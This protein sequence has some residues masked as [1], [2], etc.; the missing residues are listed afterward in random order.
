MH[1]VVLLTTGL[2]A[3]AVAM[4]ESRKRVG[5]T[6]VELLVVIA[7][8]GVL[9]ALLLPA[10]QAAREAARRSQCINNLKQIGLAVQMYHDVHQSVVPSRVPCHHAT[11]AALLWPYLEQNSASQRWLP[12][13]TFYNQPEENLQ[14][15]IST[16]LCPSRRSAPQLS[17]DGD[18]RAYISH[19]PG[20]LSDYAVAIGNGVEYTGDGGNDGGGKV[21]PNGAF[22]HARGNC[23]GADPEQ[24]LTEP[25]QPRISFKDI[26]DGLSNTIFVGEKH[27]CS[28]CNDRG[29]SIP[30]GFGLKTFDDN[31][32]YNPDFHRTIA[33]YGGVGSPIAVATDESIPPYS[34]FGSWHP[35]VC[36]FV[37][38]DGR[39]QAVSNSIDPL[40]L[41]TLCVRNDGQVIQQDDL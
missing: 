10:V 17:I 18:S 22:R 13:K 35:G 6:L 21:E 24:W 3:I 19:R 33:R 28:P 12:D 40:V 16:Y 30:D 34:N 25:F 38:G 5:F 32:V 37:F 41:D 2:G 11:W 20:G 14:I 4:N 23:I 26:E 39:A 1:D 9:V 8:I 29:K 15:Q 7:I 31:S 27:I 36:Q